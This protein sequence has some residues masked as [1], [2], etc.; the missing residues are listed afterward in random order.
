MQYQFASAVEGPF[1][2]G[3]TET[4]KDIGNN[5]ARQ[6]YLLNTSSNFEYHEMLKFIKG[7]CA[8]GA[9]LLFD[10]FNRFEPRLMSYIT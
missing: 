7:V 1:G 8:C 9:W 3:K 6:N 10:E 2:T 5:L 4:V